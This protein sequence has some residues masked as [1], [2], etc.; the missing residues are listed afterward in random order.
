MPGPR[1]LDDMARNDETIRDVAETTR[2]TNRRMHDVELQVRGLEVE[3]R[4]QTRMLDGIEREIFDY[5]KR[6]RSLEGQVVKFT[7]ISII[8]GAALSIIA[9]QIARKYFD[10]STKPPEKL[11]EKYIREEKIRD[12]EREVEDF[13]R[14]NKQ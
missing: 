10:D 8:V 9:T 12:L 1:T 14:K 11:T 3:T 7:V 6:I 2:E 4:G 13:K 5:D